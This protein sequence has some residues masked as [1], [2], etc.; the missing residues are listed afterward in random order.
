MP[1]SKKEPPRRGGSFLWYYKGMKETFLVAEDELTDLAEDVIA[2]LAKH[3]SETAKILLLEGDLGAGKTTF[4]KTLGKVLGIPYDDI[5]SPTF[6]LKKKYI[7]QHETF[8]K[9]VH[10]DAYRFEDESESD[11]LKLEDDLHEKETLIVI[12]WPSKMGLTEGDMTLSFDHDGDTTRNITI[13]YTP[14]EASL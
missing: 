2:T 12:E 10:I 9:L 6:I 1:F 3:G 7:T 8:K 5:H 4:T 11:I 14:Y 13:N